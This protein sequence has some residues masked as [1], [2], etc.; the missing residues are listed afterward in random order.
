MQM[1]VCQT[2]FPIFRESSDVEINIRETS[3]F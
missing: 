2:A 3:E 1:S